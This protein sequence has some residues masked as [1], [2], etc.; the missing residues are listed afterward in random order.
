VKKKTKVSVLEEEEKPR[1]HQNRN[2]KTPSLCFQSKT[3][4]PWIPLSP[5]EK[6]RKT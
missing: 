6:K 5:K 4:I 2:I 1:S 3:T